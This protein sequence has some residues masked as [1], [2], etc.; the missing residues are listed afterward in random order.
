[1]K[2]SLIILLL[3]AGAAHAQGFNDEPPC[4]SWSGG[5]KSSGSYSKCGTGIPP[6]PVKVAAAP[7]VAAPVMQ[8][9]V[10]PP[11][12]ILEPAPAKA[13]VKRKSAPK[14]ICK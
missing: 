14:P 9:T 3:M 1:M 11:Q 7:V 12:V 10:C 6:A 4:F 2:H 8:S 13:P 5:H